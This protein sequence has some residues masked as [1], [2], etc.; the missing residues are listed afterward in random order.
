MPLRV[1]FLTT[2]YPLKPGD[3]TPA[4]VAD[5]ARHLA[6]NPALQIKVLAPHHGG[7]AKHE[8]RDG[9]RI[10]RFQYTLNP[11]R[12]CVAY[13]GGIPD[14][15]KNLPQAKWQLPGFFA[16]MVAAVGRSLDG[17]DL[18][19]AH[20]VEP[21]FL[22]TLANTFHRRPLVVSV[23]SLKPRPTPMSRWAHR[24]ALGQADRVLF[25]SQYTQ[26]EAAGHAYRCRG[27]VIYQGF[28]PVMFASGET[29]DV[30]RNRLGI[31][32][33][34]KLLVAIG[35]MIPVKGLEILAGAA[36]AILR[37]RPDWHLIIVG[38]GPRRAAIQSIVDGS[39]TQSR[40]HLTGTLARA[41]VAGLLREADLFVNPGIVDT[42]GRAEGLGL[43]TIE[44]AASGLAT[45]GS[46]CGG[47]VETIRD[48]LT[49]LLVQPNNA[50]QLVSALHELM[51]DAAQR[52]R[53]GTA[54][55]NWAYQTFTWPTL[56][57]QVSEVYREVANLR[58]A[59]RDP[60]TRLHR[61]RDIRN[62]ES[63]YPS[64]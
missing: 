64:N 47:I 46:R 45:V 11:Y 13:G 34:S 61:V 6:K 19:H 1:L 2:T 55:R 62:Y 24:L 59:R 7:A 32:A 4:F 38:D 31:E 40:I 44:A 33:G 58:W 41:E 10:E 30:W 3:G 54:A 51:D 63:I 36:D 37:D 35:R 50:G 25:N 39:L 15:L 17:C 14:N 56:A 49:G 29:M 5:L 48:G 22:A 12:Q 8:L 52:Q 21:A 42:G 18:I 28:D 16:A 26:R 23:H 60:D 57:E 9:V 20:W 53:L 43:T 27:Q